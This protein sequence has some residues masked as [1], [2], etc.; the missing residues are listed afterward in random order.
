ME[1]TDN[2]CDDCKHK[3]SFL[4]CEKAH[5]VYLHHNEIYEGKRC[6]NFKQKR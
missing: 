4:G 5:V 6:P 2:I 3:G 1:K